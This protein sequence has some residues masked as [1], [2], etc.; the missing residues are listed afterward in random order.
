MQDDL[1][2]CEGQSSL[3]DLPAADEMPDGGWSYEAYVHFLGAPDTAALPG[4]LERSGA[5]TWEWLTGAARWPGAPGGAVLVSLQTEEDIAQA[6]WE[7]VE[8]LEETGLRVTEVRDVLRAA[9]PAAEAQPEDEAA[10]LVNNN[11]GRRPGRELLVELEHARRAWLER[12]GITL[13]RGLEQTAQIRVWWE[14]H[15]LGDDGS[16]QLR[17]L[18]DLY[19]RC[20]ETT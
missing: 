4:N 3:F 8:A 19:S 5:A 16:S 15:P 17:T 12:A 1:D 13:E 14:Q 10:A 18:T 6:L 11:L 9:S 20:L 2:I 7:T